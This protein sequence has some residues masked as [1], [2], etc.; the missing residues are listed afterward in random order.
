MLTLPTGSPHPYI[1]AGFSPG[2]RRIIQGSPAVTMLCDG[3][4][5][6]SV[7]GWRQVACEKVKLT[8]EWFARA[9]PSRSGSCAAAH[10]LA[11]SPYGSAAGGR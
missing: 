3:T 9:L 8:K 7:D 4:Y 2:P 5:P 10:A 6:A 11:G 1:A